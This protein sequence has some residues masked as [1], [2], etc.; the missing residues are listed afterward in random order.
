VYQDTGFQGDAP[1]GVKTLQP[2]KTPKG[3]AL[4]PEQQEH[5]RLISSIRIV[6]EPIISGIKRC[7]IV[8]TLADYERLKEG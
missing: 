5:T 3:K 8:N 7:R 6:I 1:D 2:Q 4:T